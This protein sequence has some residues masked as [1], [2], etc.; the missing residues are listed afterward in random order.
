MMLSNKKYKLIFTSGFTRDSLT[1]MSL[2]CSYYQTLLWIITSICYL[3]SG[4][5]ADKTVHVHRNVAD[6]TV[7]LLWLIVM[8][9]FIIIYMYVL[10]TLVLI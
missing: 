3:D 4:V 1:D 6:E 7:Q 8:R 10:L 9:L 5:D 2:P